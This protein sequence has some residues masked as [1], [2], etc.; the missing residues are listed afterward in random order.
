MPT[1]SPASTPSSARWW[2]S[3]LAR[4]SIWA[5]VR[6]WPS[7]TRYSRSPKW[8]TLC[9][10]RSARLYSTASVC[11]VEWNGFSFH[12]QGSLGRR[13][14]DALG[15]GQQLT[16]GR[17]PPPAHDAAPGDLGDTGLVVDAGVER[18]GLAHLDRQ[19][20]GEAGGARRHLRAAEQVVEGGGHEAAVEAA[21]RALVGLA[22]HRRPDGPSPS[23]RSRSGGASGLER[24]LMPL[25]SV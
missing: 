1:C 16:A 5:Y 23:T 12:G 9:S 15:L 18:R 6:R 7:A 3:R 10:K 13:D 4:S 8:S 22:V 2:A 25:R 24:P 20:P 19:R 17:R 14:E 11:L 21:R